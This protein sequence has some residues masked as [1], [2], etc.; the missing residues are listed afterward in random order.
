MTTA[1]T[2]GRI[3]ASAATLLTL[4]G[5]AGCGPNT[6]AYYE[7]QTAIQNH[8]TNVDHRPVASVS[9]T[10]HVRDTMRGDTAHLRCVVVFKDGTSYTANAEIVN[11]NDGGRHNMP[12][13]YR[14]D[15]PPQP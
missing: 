11:Q 7:L 3:L 9:C 6:D 14:W 8:I 10:P 5:A 2:G 13:L 12:D 15:A 1:R 4:A